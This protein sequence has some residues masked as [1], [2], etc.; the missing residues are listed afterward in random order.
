MTP[1]R[2]TMRLDPVRP[3]DDERK[4]DR[5]GEDAIRHGRVTGGTW[6]SP[7]PWVKRED[8]PETVH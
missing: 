8:K 5:R 7:M 4:D 1:T 3:D 6:H 2:T